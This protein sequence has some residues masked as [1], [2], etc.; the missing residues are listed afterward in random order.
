MRKKTVF[1]GLSG[2]VDSSV[3]ALLLKQKYKVVGV[4]IRTWSPSFIKCTWREERRDAMRV[5][6]KLNIPFLECDA[7]EIYKKNVVDYMIQ[8]YKEGKT[9]NPDVMC[10][11]EVKFGVFWQFAKGRGA[12]Y[13]A[14][15][16]Y[17]RN[18]DGK[19]LK[20]RD[21]SKDQSYFLWKLTKEDLKHILFPIGGINK[22]K[23]RRIANK[24]KLFTS[25]KK[26]SQGICFLGP[27]D[28][29]N[30]LSHYI[31]T[32]EGNVLNRKGR[33]IGKHSGSIFYTLGE[34]H[35]FKV[36]SKKPLYVVNKDVN[37][38]IITVSSKQNM[39]NYKTNVCELKDI[40][41][42]EDLEDKE[43]KAQIRY[44]GRLYNCRID[45]SRII[46][47][48]DVLVASGQSIVFYDKDVCIGGGV[49]R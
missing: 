1:V 30:F 14:T 24:Y 6:A 32:K 5:C 13:I 49:V 29:K 19:L 10:N 41:L 35:G 15:G 16:H 37:K 47:K 2:G 22:E 27:I 8:E 12:D 7:E 4:F 45:K 44:H 17:A 25:T 21:K 33:I 34:R 42:I 31:K 36:E 40:N 46:F 38:N 28:L 23:V 26:D 48:K 39:D 43:Y 18:K 11:R 3:S 20:G 9:P